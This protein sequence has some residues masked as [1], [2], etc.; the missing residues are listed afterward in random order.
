MFKIPVHSHPPNH[1]KLSCQSS[2][3]KWCFIM[4][5]ICFSMVTN[6]LNIH[7]P[8]FSFFKKKKYWL[9]MSFVHFLLV[10]ILICRYVDLHILDVNTLSVTCYEMLLKDCILTLHPLCAVLRYPE[11][12][13]LNAIKIISLYF[14]YFK[15]CLHTLNPIGFTPIHLF[16]F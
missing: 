10:L 1:L 3:G 15:K 14:T 12:L 8:V 7:F 4:V 16:T 6:G 9:F 5:L 2:E 13:N 11:V